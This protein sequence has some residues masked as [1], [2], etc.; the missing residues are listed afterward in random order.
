MQRNG[1]GA[2]IVSL[3][4]PAGTSEWV[5]QSLQI[6]KFIGHPA[7]SSVTKASRPVNWSRFGKDAES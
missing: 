3:T 6:W 1:D 4:I 5:R 7:L 2:Q